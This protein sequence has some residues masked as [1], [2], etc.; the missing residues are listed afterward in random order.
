MALIAPSRAPRGQ[1]VRGLSSGDRRNLRTGLLFIS[2]WL[3][4]F[5]LFTLYPMVASL[6]YSFSSVRFG[7]ATGFVGFNNY[8]S[9]LRDPN[10]LLSLGNTL[11]IV[12][13]AVPLQLVVSFV[14]ALLLNIKVPGQSLYR[15]IYY[16]PA[17]MPSVAST[18]LWSWLLRADNGLIN[19]MLGAIGIQGPLWTVSP[20]WAKPSLVLLG[21]W[22]IGNTMMIYLAGLQDVPTSLH[23]AAELDGAGWFTRLWRITIP[24]V[25]SITLFNLIIGVIDAFQYFSQAYVLAR[26]APGGVGL[27]APEGSTLFYAVLLYSKLIEQFKIG[28]ASAMAWILFV[29]V[30]CCTLLILKFSNRFTYYADD[31]R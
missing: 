13:I 8:A 2:P 3:V 11:Y 12:L 28:E 25:S 15:V 17:I 10:F 23:E 1:S 22:G 16:L 7:Q 27:G 5:A 9:L 18:L 31:D 20:E 30:L 6:V 26:L 29:I 4:G 24:M 14:C 19:S 21:L